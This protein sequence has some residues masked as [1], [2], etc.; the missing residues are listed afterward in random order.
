MKTFALA[1]MAGLFWVNG[2]S[3]GELGFPTLREPL[4]PP[5]LRES[6]ARPS[7]MDEMG[8]PGLKEPSAPTQAQ[9]S[10]PPS[11]AGY[12]AA[13][14]STAASEL[15]RTRFGS[16]MP[17]P[18]GPAGSAISGTGLGDDVLAPETFGAAALAPRAA[19]GALAPESFGAAALAPGPSGTFDAAALAPGAVDP[20][21]APDETARDVVLGI[22]PAVLGIRP[23]AGALLKARPG[24]NLRPKPGENSPL[25]SLSQTESGDDA[26]SAD[27][28]T[29]NGW[30]AFLGKGFG[31]SP[32][33]SGRHASSEPDWLPRNR[34]AAFSGP[35]VEW[36]YMRGAL[37]R[38]VNAIKNWVGDY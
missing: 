26:D 18:T 23:A 14:A 25:N 32:L 21:A 20:A 15:A 29:D 33:Q 8:V 16:P 3:A 35:H 36:D 31:G 17:S 9:G 13:P 19:D 22:K 2:V 37:K 38:G 6:L 27:S 5:P 11:S 30:S 4:A 12:A 34:T 24:E 7:L 10:P 28:A 1:L